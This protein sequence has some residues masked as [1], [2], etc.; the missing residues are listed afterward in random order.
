[1]ANTAPIFTLTP[2]CKTARIATA[3]TNRDGSGTL[4]SVV[5]GGASGT[6]IDRILVQATA[7]TTAGMV[8]LFVD[9]G[10]N[11]RA[12]GEIPVTAITPSA[13]VAAFTFEVYR[14]DGLPVAVLPSG[15]ILKAGTHNA[16]SFDVTAFG[17]EY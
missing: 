3:N 16:E 17:G 13:T 7:T 4:G 11:I 9:D 6:R 8:R 14:L 10:T 12:I 1:M 15:Y 2:V 5:T